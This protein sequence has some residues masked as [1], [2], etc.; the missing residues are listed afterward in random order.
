M[1]EVLIIC[2]RQLVKTGAR[3]NMPPARFS[4]QGRLRLTNETPICYQ[5]RTAVL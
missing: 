2:H 5:R 4:G 1:T 3:L